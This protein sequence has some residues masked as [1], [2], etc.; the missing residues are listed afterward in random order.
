MNKIA[1]VAVLGAVVTTGCATKEYVHEYVDG[2]LK[3]VKAHVQSVD[4]REAR[5]AVSVKNLSMAVEANHAEAKAALASQGE[6]IAGNEAAIGK[7]SAD[8]GKHSADIAQL[9][10]TAQEAVD[11]ATASGKLAAGKLVYEVVLTDD[12]LKFKSGSAALSPEAMAALDDFAAKLKSDNKNVY[13]EIQGHTDS[14]GGVAANLRLGEARA[15]SVLRHLNMKGGIPLHRLAAISYGESA[16]V[17]DNM[18][19]AGRSQN[20]RVVLVVFQ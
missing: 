7:N 9:S 15:Q 3:P 4:E 8:I 11:R 10:K 16:P 2:Q 13:I 19:M 6:R 12:T 1:L 20:R 14:R 5:T 18:N 17:A